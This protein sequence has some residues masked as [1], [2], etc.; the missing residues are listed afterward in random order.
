MVSLKRYFG[1]LRA[2]RLFAGGVTL[3]WA[4]YFGATVPE[5]PPNSDGVP[6]GFAVTIVL[7]VQFAGTLIAQVGYVLPAGTGRFRFG[8]LADRPAVVRA[9]AGTGTFAT[10]VF[11]LAV[12]GWVLPDSMP[13]LVSGT[14]AFTWLGGVVGAAVGVV[15]TVLLAAGTG[16]VRLSRGEPV[17]DAAAD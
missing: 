11:L 5:P 12:L 10:L 6:T 15:L 7:L 14:Y 1:L 16:I 17:F 9:A 3:C 8:P 13:S 4:I 2:T